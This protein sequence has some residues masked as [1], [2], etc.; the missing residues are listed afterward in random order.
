MA[1]RSEVL[2]AKMFLLAACAGPRGGVNGAGAGMTD[3]AATVEKAQQELAAAER[4]LAHFDESERP[5][6]RPF[7]RSAPCVASSSAPPLGC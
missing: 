6:T 4:T 2:S 3:G 1:I 7:R 5:Q